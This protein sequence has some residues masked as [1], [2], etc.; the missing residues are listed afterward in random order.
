MNNVDEVRPYLDISGL[1]IRKEY[2]GGCVGIKIRS[3]RYEQRDEYIKFLGVVILR[4]TYGW[5]LSFALNFFLFL[6]DKF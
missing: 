2:K 1:P 6:K 3:I 5:E 4:Q